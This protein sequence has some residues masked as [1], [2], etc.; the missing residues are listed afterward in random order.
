MLF[1]INQIVNGSL[2]FTINI[3]VMMKNK[4]IFCI[5]SKKGA[6]CHSKKYM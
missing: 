2:S 5:E 6:G 1:F 4:I 3:T